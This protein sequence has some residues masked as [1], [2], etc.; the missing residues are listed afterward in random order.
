[1]VYFYGVMAFLFVLVALLIHSGDTCW[2]W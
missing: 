1:M 2:Q